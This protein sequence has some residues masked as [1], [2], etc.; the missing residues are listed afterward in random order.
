MISLPGGGKCL[1]KEQNGNQGIWVENKVNEIFV[2]GR[3]EKAEFIKFV[4]DVFYSTFKE[5]AAL[6]LYPS[7][8]KAFDLDGIERK[9][10]SVEEFVMYY[11]EVSNER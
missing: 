3:H 4:R 7:I 5:D 6:S 8:R 2:E 9:E 11:I 10:F 1:A